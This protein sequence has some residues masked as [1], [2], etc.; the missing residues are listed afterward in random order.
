MLSAVARTLVRKADTVFVAVGRNGMNA[1][2]PPLAL[3]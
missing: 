1:R 3:S 2:G